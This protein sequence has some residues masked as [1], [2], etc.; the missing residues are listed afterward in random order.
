M[1]LLKIIVG[2][3]AVFTIAL[4]AVA[5]AVYLELIS[6][7]FPLRAAEPE[8]SARLYPPDVVAYSWM[9]LS[10]GI[11]QLRDMGD[12]LSRLE[13]LPEFERLRD[14]AADGFEDG[15]GVDFEDEIMPWLGSSA[16][17]ALFDIGGDDDD[18]AVEMAGTVEVRDRAAAEDALEKRLDFVEDMR[19]A[20]FARDFDGDFSV[21]SDES[22][23]EFYALSDDL[24][25]FATSRSAI[26][27]VIRRAGG[28]TERTLAASERFQRARS[29]MP[30]RRFT[31]AYLDVDELMD[32]LWAGELGFDDAAAYGDCVDEFFQTPD[33]LAASAG[34][35]E[36]GVV[37]EF[38]APSSD[39][40]ALPSAP[41][42]ADAASWL[43]SDTMG[44]F[45]L[46]FDPVLANWRA[47][48]ADYA[49]AD[50][51]DCFPDA[52]EYS[53]MM[54]VDMSGDLSDLLD[55]ALDALDTLIGIDV[56]SDLMDNL[57]GQMAVAVGE[58]DFGQ[59][60]E[61]PDQ[62]PIHAAAALSY[63]EGA[64]GDLQNLIDDLTEDVYHDYGLQLQETDVG[65]ERPAT[66]YEIDGTRYAP[67]VVA[68]GGFLTFATTR[69]ALRDIADVQAG[70]EPALSSDPEYARALSHLPADR[71][72]LL[73][74][75]LR[76]AADGI[77][78]ADANLTR[79]QMEALETVAGAIAISATESDGF[80]RTTMVVTLFGGG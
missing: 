13:D 44:F 18:D 5:G 41:P 34:W 33:W 70:R 55:E 25:I 23:G 8:K 43:P 27:A 79:D 6:L 63:K 58:F 21:W 53:D 50:I 75:D 1:L 49:I 4:G 68:S 2:A 20:D 35:V 77:D 59:V 15:F 39:S 10:P 26:R 54:G 52:Y 12:T 56:E 11:G 19:G 71:H 28:E 64:G 16:S 14:D 76:R 62:A 67:G 61:N 40:F 32:T 48:L 37:F 47:A 29:A 73:Y 9:S 45:A 31:S 60:S 80:G 7:P 65:A 69:R 57:G 66:V 74:I 30:S 38:V 46:S 17:L 72:W 51:A 78:R 42:L 3:V 22:A 24:M 36:R